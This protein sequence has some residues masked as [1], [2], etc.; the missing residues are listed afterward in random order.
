[1]LFSYLDYLDPSVDSAKQ[2]EEDFQNLA[3]K[4]RV[5]NRQIGKPQPAK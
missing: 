1:M 4:R 2:I 5:A 3:K